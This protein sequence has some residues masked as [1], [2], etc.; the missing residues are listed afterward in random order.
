VIERQ[1]ISRKIGPFEINKI[2]VLDCLE[3]MSKLPDKSVDLIFIDPPYN[4]GKDYGVYKDDL[5]HEDY[6]DFMK[7]VISEFRRISKRGFGI[8]LD[9]KHFQEFWQLIPEAEP[10]I[11]YK[12]SSGVVYSRLNIVQ[13]HHVI[14]TTAK[15]LTRT[16]KSLWDDIRVFGEGYLFHEETYG[17]PAQTSLKATKR[18]I[19]NFSEPG[20]VVLDCFMGTGT[21]AVACKQTNRNFIG[22]EIN[23]EYVNI[24]NKRLAQKTLDEAFEE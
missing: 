11:I 5:P 14:L 19:E 23:P 13:H 1:A 3:G 8:Y 18:F 24:A 10:I 22:F 9:W 16:C 20:E 2:Y 4:V 17:H 6:I 7:A 12:R 21:T 15:C